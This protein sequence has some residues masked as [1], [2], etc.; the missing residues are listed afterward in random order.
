MRVSVRMCMTCTMWDGSTDVIMTFDLCLT[1]YGISWCEPC[2]P[3]PHSGDP[4]QTHPYAVT[5][6]RRGHWGACTILTIAC[7]RT[8]ILLSSS[9]YMMVFSM[10][11]GFFVLTFVFSSLVICFK[12]PEKLLSKKNW[13]KVIGL[14]SY[15]SFFSLHMRLDLL[16]WAFFSHSLPSFLLSL[17]AFLPLPVCTTQLFLLF[18]LQWSTMAS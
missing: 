2:V 17:S 4:P 1:E 3:S 11:S 6:R 15:Y 7:K 9:S 10:S 16:L 18:S 13:M 8:S 14:V 12:W 5:S